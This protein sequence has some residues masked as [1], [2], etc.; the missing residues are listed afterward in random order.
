MRASTSCSVEPTATPL[1]G[2][3]DA[4]LITGMDG[5]DVLNGDSGSDFLFGEAGTDKFDLRLDIFAG[6]FDLIADLAAGE[7]IFL[8]AAF[9]SAVSYAQQ[10]DDVIG[11]INLGGG[12]LYRVWVDG[13]STP[14]TIDQVQAQTVFA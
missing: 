1:A 9:A 6:D 5:D 13:G 11:T 14:L 10:G 4:D 12:N 8:D 3:A 2:G 7:T